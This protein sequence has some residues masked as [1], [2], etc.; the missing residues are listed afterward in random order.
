MTMYQREVLIPSFSIAAG[1]TLDISLGFY[2]EP[3]FL[4]LAPPP[5][6]RAATG[7]TWTQPFAALVNDQMNFVVR[8]S[9]QHPAG[10]GL[11]LPEMSWQL[12][13][14]SFDKFTY[15]AGVE[16]SKDVTYEDRWPGHTVSA[17]SPEDMIKVGYAKE[18]PS[19]EAIHE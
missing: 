7:L 10:L 15:L 19:E 3:G 8:F 9:H 5:N 11:N 1:E 16:Q 12:G 2:T 13:F 4:L 14:I 18:N 17:I 6:I